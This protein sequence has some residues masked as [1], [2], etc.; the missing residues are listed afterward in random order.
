MK[1][2]VLIS[3]NGSNLQAIIDKRFAINLNIVCVISDKP[4][5]L[6]LTRASR[7]SIPTKVIISQGI[8]REV[9]DEK[10]RK[11]IDIYTPDIIILAGF[12]RILTPRT[13]QHYL[14]KMLNIHPSLLPKFKGLNTHKRAIESGE[15]QHGVSVHFVTQVLD[16]GAIIAQS[17]VA[18]TPLDTPESLAQKILVKEHKI[19]PQ[20]IS[21][22]SQQ[23]LILKDNTA[24]LDNKPLHQPIY[25]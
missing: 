12:M 8:E 17:I 13:T 23:R 11:T 7:I 1:A 25:V 6:G 20:V 4:N 22:F 3:G 15:T 19:Y 18:I 14:G 2:V 16:S 21:W 24:Y 5:V 9:F 10:L